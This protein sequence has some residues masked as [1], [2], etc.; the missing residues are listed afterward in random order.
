MDFYELLGVDRSATQDEIKKSYRRLARELHPDANPGDSAAEARFKQVAEAYE[1][2]SDPEKRARYDRF[3]SSG[4][5]GGGMGDPFAATGLGDLFDAF[6]NAGGRGDTA[7]KRGVDLE[8]VVALTLEEAVF[9]VAKDVSVRTAVPC[10]TCE[11]TGAN[12]GTDVS[13]CDQCGGSGQVRQVRQSILGQMVSTSTCPR[14]AGEGVQITSPCDDCSGEGRRVEEQTYNVDIPAGVNEGSTLRLTGRGAVGPRGGGAG[15]LY[16]NIRVDEHPVFARDAD[17]LF[18]DIRVAVTQAA[19]GANVP[20]ETID[21]Q[22][23]IDV[24]AGAQGGKRYRLRD[25]GVPRLRGRGRGDLILT[26]VIDTPTDLS[27]EQEELLRQLAKERHEDVKD[28]GED[29][30]LG[31]FKSRFN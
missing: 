30:L 10:D 28:P 12:P 8:A 6:F 11:A 14:C 20:F 13:R 23:T 9:G 22:V 19:L 21:G 29:G 25:R 17:D 7:T 1:V 5:K 3:G 2:L 15:D 26:L 16:V 27:A 4:V 24:G 18:A 31:R